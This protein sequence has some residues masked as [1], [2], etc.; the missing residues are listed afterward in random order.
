M[1]HANASSLSLAATLVWQNEQ[2]CVCVCL[3]VLHWAHDTTASHLPH[4]H[5]FWSDYHSASCGDH[6]SHSVYLFLLYSSFFL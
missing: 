2:H 5:S 6:S 3:K 4:I 1:F